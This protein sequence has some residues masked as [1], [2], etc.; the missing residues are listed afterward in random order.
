VSDFLSDKRWGKLFDHPSNYQTVLVNFVPKNY[1]HPVAGIG[2]QH[3]FKEHE[4]KRADYYQQQM[5]ETLSAMRGRAFDPLPL[6]G[7]WHVF[8]WVINH[9]D[10]HH[11]LR[12]S[13]AEMDQQL[14]RFV[15][16][17]FPLQA[18]NSQCTWIP[19]FD[20]ADSYERTVYEDSS[21]LNW[22]RGILDNGNG[23]ESDKMTARWCGNV[24]RMVT[25]HM[26]LCQNLIDQV[27]KAALEHVAEV[28]ETN[29]IY[30]VALRPGSTLDALELALLPILPVEN[31]RISLV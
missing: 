26:W 18:W 16:E 31:T 20:L 24:L 2:L 28:S 22:F 14:D 5:A 15:V 25:P 29:G 21:T 11:S 4:E 12:T 10:C 19:T 13:L 7:A 8:K 27:D 3:S 30:K 17:Q 9:P 23:L 1:D 6:G